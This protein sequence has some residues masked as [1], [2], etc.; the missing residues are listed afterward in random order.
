MRRKDYVPYPSTQGVV[1]TTSPFD[2]RP[3]GRV[4]APNAWIPGG[5]VGWIERGDLV[6]W[7]EG[8]DVKGALGGAP[9]RIG[10][11]IGL[12]MRG[13]SGPLPH[14]FLYVIQASDDFHFGY[15]RLID[16]EDVKLINRPAGAFARWFFSG[17]PGDPVDVY[18]VGEYGGLSDNYLD[19]HVEEDS[20][21]PLLHANDPSWHEQQR[22]YKEHDRDDNPIPRSYMPF[23][24]LDR[25]VQERRPLPPINERGRFMENERF[26]KI[27]TTKRD[28]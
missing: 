8:E 27:R 22:N 25:P 7:G 24:R 19:K 18:K 17:A 10:R 2:L 16:P 28:H 20:G 4:R 5:G 13:G 26:R 6:T 23:A 15:G 1:E 21:R 12:A 11:V 3:I 14:P 9:Q